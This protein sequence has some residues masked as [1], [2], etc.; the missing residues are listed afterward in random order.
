MSNMSANPRRCVSVLW[1]VAGLLFTVAIV[2]SFSQG[3]TPEW[4]K[5]GLR[6]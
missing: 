1:L 4:I 5:N 6:K 2:H 3:G